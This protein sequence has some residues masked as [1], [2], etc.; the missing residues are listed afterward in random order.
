MK[1]GSITKLIKDYSKEQDNNE[2]EI[3]EELDKTINDLCTEMKNIE[4][5]SVKYC[6][7]CK[8]IFD[9]TGAKANLCTKFKKVKNWK[10]KKKSIYINSI[11]KIMI[12]YKFIKNSNLLY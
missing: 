12:V 11:I 3:D 5:E 2:I 1:R 7:N 9:L 10:K 8:E 6:N 4:I